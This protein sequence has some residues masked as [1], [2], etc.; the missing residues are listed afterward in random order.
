MSEARIQEASRWIDEGDRILKGGGGSWQ[1]AESAYASALQA[2][3]SERHSVEEHNLY[4]RASMNRGNLLAMQGTVQGMEE[5]LAAYDRAEA[6]WL[7][8]PEQER[9][10]DMRADMAALSGNQGHAWLRLGNQER[11]EKGVNYYQR[12]VDL[13]DPLP[14][15][16]NSRFHHHLIGAW[17][18]LGNAL[19]M[20]DNAHLDTLRC[21]ENALTLAQEFQIREPGH[22]SLIA[23][24]W[25]NYGNTLGRS[26]DNAELEKAL[27]CYD[28]AIR[29][30]QHLALQPGQPQGYELASAWA[31]RA[32]LLSIEQREWSNPQ[33]ALIAVQN[34]LD[35]VAEQEEKDP[36]LAEIS[37]KARRARCQAY[38]L[39]F[40]DAGE[41]SDE[42]YHAASD[43]VDHALALVRIWEERNI[44][45][46]RPI[47]QRLFL[48]GVNLYRIRQPQFLAEFIEETLN[49]IPAEEFWPIAREAVATALV[50][51]REKQTLTLGT[52]TT[53]SLLQT[54]R[55]LEQLQ[56][57]LS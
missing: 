3:E 45:A 13:L 47:A 10:Q 46:F 19:Q 25:L 17:F 29:L 31:N 8:I 39:L 26:E 18:N 54:V 11:W 20:A 52:K 6:E 36:F 27:R 37:L 1:E 42:Y 50:D 34:A 44:T 32:N 33:E 51:L 43:E 9:T 4:A 35:W 16:D 7:A 49:S 15:R 12:A 40:P 28:N 48:F 2:L 53:D 38:G 14:W 55:E 41:Q 56:E 30:F 22:F 57:R 23:S 24:I 21:Y 5:A